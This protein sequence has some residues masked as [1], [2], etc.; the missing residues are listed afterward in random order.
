MNISE[1]HDLLNFWINKVQGE[2]Y[3]PEELDM[4]L[5][6]GQMSLYQDLQPKYATS[7]RIKDALS[8][9][10]GVYNFGYADT[11]LGVLTIP[12]DHSALNILDLQI[13]YD[14]SAR[15][16]VK[17]VPIAL[18]NEDERSDRLNSQIDPVSAT[19]PVGEQI[20]ENS[21]QLYP[22]VQYRG[23]ITFLKRPQAPVFAYNLVSGRVIVYDAA[24][25]TQLQ[26]RE[27][28][29][30]SVIIKALSSIGI[31][32]SSQEIM[33]WAEQKSIQNVQGINKT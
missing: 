11:V 24:N 4:I 8:P 18:V 19:A 17:Y 6:R 30:N 16:I 25:S 1:I 28:E 14:I 22:K 5:D 3:S 21:F 20:G 29:Q 27:T 23:S 15:S 32:I 10:R 33:Q 12:S 31:N 9:F 26:W 13:T 7:Q 2:F